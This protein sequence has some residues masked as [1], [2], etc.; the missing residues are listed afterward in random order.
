MADLGCSP[1]HGASGRRKSR[2][3]APAEAAPLPAPAEDAPPTPPQTAHPTP[4]PAAQ[5]ETWSTHTGAQIQCELF[6]AT[7]EAVVCGIMHEPTCCVAIEGLPPAWPGA[8]GQSAPGQSAPG[9]NSARLPCGHVFHPAALALHFLVADM[10]CPV[11]RVGVAET[12]Q[13]ESVP[14]ELRLDFQKK[15]EGIDRREKD[16]EQEARVDAPASIADVLRD[17]ELQVRVSDETREL[18]S[19]RTPIIFSQDQIEQIRQLQASDALQECNFA[20]HRSFQRLV[21][22]LVSRQSCQHPERRVRF[23]LQHPLVPVSMVSDEVSMGA[24]WSELFDPVQQHT[25]SPV[26]LFCPHVTGAEPVA[27]L[28]VVFPDHSTVRNISTTRISTP[29]ISTPNISTPNISI[30]VNICFLMNIATYVSEVLESVRLAVEQHV[31]MFDSS[32][33]LEVTH[34]TVNGL[35]LH[36]A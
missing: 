28:R 10:R 19:M 6:A 34:H 36:P 31:S 35:E 14:A 11:C 24:V 16:S 4:P 3:V 13:L 12:M 27:H 33:V 9:P 1:S 21:A 32:S 18:T 17:L 7:D 25:R 15:L 5:V 20:V 29:R 23:A 26:P 2:R 8:P 22:A 30:D